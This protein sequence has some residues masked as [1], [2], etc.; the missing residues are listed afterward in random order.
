MK[1]KKKNLKDRQLKR[2]FAAMKKVEMTEGSKERILKDIMVPGS[3]LFKGSNMPVDPADILKNLPWHR[4][5]T[6]RIKQFFT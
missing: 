6:R 1:K 4:R 5:L 3:G 2:M